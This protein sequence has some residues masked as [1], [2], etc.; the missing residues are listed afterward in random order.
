MMTVTGSIEP[1]R[2]L[3]EQLVQASPDFLRGL[4]R[5]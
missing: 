1:A 5:S 2:L 4:Q 3:E